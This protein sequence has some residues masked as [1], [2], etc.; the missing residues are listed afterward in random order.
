MARNIE[1]LLNPAE[2]VEPADTVVTGMSKTLEELGLVLTDS[3]PSNKQSF[4]KQTDITLPVDDGVSNIDKIF[5]DFEA[6]FDSRTLAEASVSFRAGGQLVEAGVSAFSDEGEE[7]VNDLR[8]VNRKS[9][10]WNQMRP[11]IWEAEDR[12]NSIKN[13]SSREYQLEWENLANLRENFASA[14]L[15]GANI[16]D[17]GEL[18]FFEILEKVGDNKAFFAGAMMKAMFADPG[19]M[20]VGGGWVKAGN[21]AL[22]AA[23]ALKLAQ[24]LQTTAKLTGTTVGAGTVG[25][26]FGAA[27]DIVEQID[28]NPNNPI[29]FDRVANTSL[30]VGAITAPLPIIGTAG[31]TLINAGKIPVRKV[32]EILDRRKI[33]KVEKSAQ[34]I[35]NNSFVDGEATI[36]KQLA[37]NKAIEKHNPSPKAQD[38]LPDKDVFMSDSVLAQRASEEADNL[39]IIKKTGEVVSNV[40]KKTADIWND[41]S[42]PITSTLRNM[43]YP[44]IARALNIHAMDLGTDLHIKQ[45]IVEEFSKAYGN[46]SK[47]QQRTVA[48]NLNNGT[49]LSVANQF[50]DSFRNTVNNVRKALD[51]EFTEMESMGIK[52]N[53]TENYF[54][55]EMNYEKFAKDNGL[56]LADVGQE[57]A[58][59]VN[60]KLNLSGGQK[61]TSKDMTGDMIRKHLT[62][63]EVAE[64]LVRKAGA[65]QPK[66]TVKTATRSEESRTIETVTPEL[67]KYYSDPRA[68]LHNHINRVTVKIHDRR[69]FGGKNIDK[70]IDAF[71]PGAN[72]DALISSYIKDHL[73]RLSNTGNIDPAD[74]DK[75]ER[76]LRAR[77]IGAKQKTNPII[78]GL[79]NLLYAATIG[80]PVAASVQLGDL[81]AAGYLNGFKGSVNGIIGEAI[82]GTRFKM[83][84]FGLETI[85][86][87]ETMGATKIILD[88]SLRLGAFRAMDRL[89]KEAILNSTYKKLRSVMNNPN[90]DNAKKFQYFKDRYGQRLGQDEVR[91]IMDGVASGDPKNPHA[92]LAMYSDLTK[93]QPTSMAEMPIAYLNHPNMRIFFMLKTFTLKQIDLMRNEVIN[94][95]RNS[96]KTGHKRNIAKATMNLAKLAG[97]IGAANMGVQWTRDW[98]VG[99]EKEFTDTMVSTIFRNYGISQYDVDQILKGEVVK[100]VGNIIVPP[101]QVIEN[102]LKEAM[103]V[104]TKG[105]WIDS[106][107][108]IGRTTR[109]IQDSINK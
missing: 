12:L 105:R 85:P 28:E 48:I 101:F 92:R 14:I 13:E 7:F 8:E 60:S 37:V 19:F 55:R 46:L 89:G 70:D 99:K 59:K 65:L 81:G 62:E 56:N 36:S 23:K 24:G 42:Q 100:T 58:K 49:F 75:V 73:A 76:I 22:N 87:I 9:K 44:N 96:A 83:K 25:A 107:P 45:G 106:I 21:A 6:G 80:N 104:D 72:D 57:L 71:Q 50:D 68:A 97:T 5:E 74:M 18:D 54:P 93:T 79:K 86:E 109:F 1:E 11:K 90:W 30:F 94:E 64:V 82:E 29:D 91:K 17:N 32:A 102:P 34:D 38:K 98:M 33:T 77:F 84:N 78:G 63:R 27:F 47:N 67:M 40:G 108:V 16:D 20:A 39:G 88:W 52:V 66:S 31:K 43:G 103:G 41:L 4:V 61:L 51:N 2:P 10:L 95:L 3:E 15:T 69:F 53:K 35:Y 26:G